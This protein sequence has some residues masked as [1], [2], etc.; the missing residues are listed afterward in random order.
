[1]KVNWRILCSIVVYMPFSNYILW[2]FYS[3]LILVIPFQENHKLPRLMTNY[4]PLLTQANS[5]REYSADL[6]VLLD[7]QMLFKVEVSRG[8]INYGWRNYAVKRATSDGNIIQQ[9]IKKHELKV[10]LY[11]NIS[12]SNFFIGYICTQVHNLMAPMHMVVSA[13][14]FCWRWWYSWSRWFICKKCW[15]KCKSRR[16]LTFLSFYYEICLSLC[17]GWFYLLS[18]K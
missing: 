2:L 11:F 5:S 16:F 14:G 17:Y 4:Y 15:S 9:F 18:V 8:N 3:S 1:M 6:D 12:F 10:V 13:I 7:K